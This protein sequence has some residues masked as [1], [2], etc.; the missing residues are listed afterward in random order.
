MLY[1]SL[2]SQIISC[3]YKVHNTLGNGYLEKIY[4]NAMLFECK[5]AGLRVINQKAVSVYYG[6]QQIG[7]YIADLLIENRVLVELQAVKKYR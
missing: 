1:S 3:A 7:Q 2:T 5:K 4:E 6:N